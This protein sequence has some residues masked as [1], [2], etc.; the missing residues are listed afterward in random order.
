[1][2]TIPLKD[3]ICP[4]A[5]AC[6]PSGV[7]LVGCKLTHSLYALHPASGQV[8]LVAGGGTEEGAGAAPRDGVGRRAVLACPSRLAVCAAECCAYVGAADPLRVRRVS[9]PKHWFVGPHTP[10]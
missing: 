4:A 1:M 6:T 7:L 10:S 5:L 3:G 8:S 9:L 2:T